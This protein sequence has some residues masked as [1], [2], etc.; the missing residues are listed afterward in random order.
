MKLLQALFS[1]VLLFARFLRLENAIGS[2]RGP[3]EGSLGYV[4]SLSPLFW[5]FISV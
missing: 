2:A 3:K 5:Q 4:R 1:M